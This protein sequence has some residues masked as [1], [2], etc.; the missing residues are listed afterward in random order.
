MDNKYNNYIVFDEYRT[1][2][3]GAWNFMPDE[4]V[5]FK[6]VLCRLMP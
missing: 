3:P 2:R 4:G 5:F 6:G 1:N